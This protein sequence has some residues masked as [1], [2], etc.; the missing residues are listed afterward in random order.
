[1][2]LSK[3]QQDMHDHVTID[4]TPEMREQLDWLAAHRERSRLELARELFAEG[5]KLEAL[6]RLDF[7]EDSPVAKLVND[8]PRQPYR[9]EAPFSDSVSGTTLRF[10]R[11]SVLLF[12]RNIPLGCQIFCGNS[13]MTNTKRISQYRNHHVDCLGITH[14]C[15]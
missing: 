2:A 7:S 9:Q 3:K 5:R 15:T 1:M 12:T 10:N 13:H 4:L 6:I 8:L 11:E 14:P